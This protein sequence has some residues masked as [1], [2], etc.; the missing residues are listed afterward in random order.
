MN[1][2]DYFLIEYTIPFLGFL[3]TLLAQIY[4][5]SSYNKYR[6]IPTSGKK[7]GA[8]TARK[9]LDA[10]GLENV[11]INKITG[12]L[13]DHYD[14][15]NKTVNLSADIYDGTSISSVSVAAHECGH[16]IQDKEG[17]TFMKI[18][19]LL[20]PI[21]N[22]SSKIGYLVVIIGLIF[23]A[24]GLAKFGLILLLSI[25]LFQLITLP[26]EFNAS[27]RAKKQLI[28]LNIVDNDELSDSSS[29]LRAAA[30]T[31]VASL[32]TSLL[33]ILRLA[34]IVFGRDKD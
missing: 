29:M 20:V 22:F 30:F 4:V 6:N 8:D 19:S 25:L 1:Y 12:N 14:P 10:N 7:T 32:V 5:M 27:S 33:Q 23:N 15:R 16:A 9:I 31:Y 13:T 21:T 26:V 18:R 11:K 17:Y 3:I 28:K 24:I 34:L 2:N